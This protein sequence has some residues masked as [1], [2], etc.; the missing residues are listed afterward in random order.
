MVDG[1]VKDIGEK[2]ALLKDLKATTVVYGVPGNHEYFSGY[3]PWMDFFKS[4]GVRM[5]VNE[6]E[7]IDGVIFAGITDKAAWRYK[8][9]GPDIK[10]AVGTRCETSPVI[11]FSH[12]PEHV[13][14]AEKH[15]VDLQISGHTHGGIIWGMDILVG[16]AN[17][18]YFSGFYNVGNTRLYVSNGAGIWRGL[19]IRLGRNSELTVFIL[20]APGK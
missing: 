20:K 7:A 6:A 19:P 5:L 4:I 14:V 3:K 11:L 12:R 16:I 9:K 17:G 1:K 8:Q 10:R 13:K 2:V 15:K 18:G